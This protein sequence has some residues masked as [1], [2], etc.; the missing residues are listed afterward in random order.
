[1]SSPDIKLTPDAIR[2][3]DSSIEAAVDDI[4]RLCKRRFWNAIETNVWDWP[5]FQRAYPW[6]IWMDAKEVADNAGTGPLGVA[7]VI[8]TGVQSSNPKVIPLSALFWQPRN[9]GPPWDA[10]EINRSTAYSYGLSNTPQE[11][12][13]IMAVYGYWTQTKSGGALAA[14]VSSTSA[15]TVT[16][17]DGAV[18]GVGDVIN[19]DTEALLVRD[20]AMTD[21]GQAQQGSGCSTAETSDNVLAVT[22]GTKYFID[23]ILQL[24]AE[25][26]HVLSISGNN[27]TVERSYNGTVL[28]THSGAEVYAQRLLTV[29]R[30]FGGS[31]AATHL[32][33]AGI[34]VDIVPG[35]VRE[36]A[37]AESLNYVYQKTDAYARTIGENSSIVPGGSLPD[38]RNRVYEGFARKARQR[39]V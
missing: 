18:L 2:H 20:R 24:D 19:I 16:V 3:V 29:Q 38:L 32:N 28:A 7:P 30:G 1:M 21:S 11:D 25:W 15:T 22:D 8:T 26:L 9:Y 23:E 5:N 14:A 35:Q 10:I 4:E 17:S 12:V 39:H 34:T 31:T 33:S 37:I 36:L 27:L 13:S 6:R